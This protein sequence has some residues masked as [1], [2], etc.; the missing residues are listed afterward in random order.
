MSLDR[1]Q[2][3]LEPGIHTDLD[4]RMTYAGY[5][6]LDRLLSAQRPLSDP[7]HHDEML[8][9][10]QHQV[11]E[12]WLKLLMHELQAARAFLRQDLVGQSRKVM[13]R[14]KQVLRQLI[15]QWSV[16]ETLTPSEYM[17]F[18]DLLG[19]ASGFQS[20]QY[21]AVEFLL[22]NKNAEM[23]KV[24]AHDPE[25]QAVLRRELETPSLY[26]EFLRY[27][28]R[29]GHAIPA[30]YL[31]GQRDWTAPHVSDPALLPVFDQ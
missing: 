27:L 18:R 25:G 17:G 23:V 9:I 4:G 26:E 21:R 20:L 15:E 16:L 11:A 12:L 24:F 5:L 3:P 10:I 7:P 1:N 14:G 13:A 29:F 8:F 28:A 30:E 31:A 2:R 22:G 6:Q 19:P